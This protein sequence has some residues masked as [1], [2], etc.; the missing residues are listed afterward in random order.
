MKLGFVRSCFLMMALA[1]S[2]GCTHSVHLVNFS[3]D[4]PLPKKKSAQPIRSESEQF[5]VLWVAT[6]T[7]YADKAYHGLIKQCPQGNIGGIATK[8]Y[9]DHGFFSWT[10]KIVMEGYCYN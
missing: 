4:V 6:D 2:T 3:D 10:N 7:D 9:T 1:L 8:Y 5:V